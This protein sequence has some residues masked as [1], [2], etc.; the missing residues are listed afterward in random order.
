MTS[1]GPEQQEQAIIEPTVLDNGI[2]DDD[3]ELAA[4]A[5][6]ACEIR[7]MEA[8]ITQ[9]MPA[10]ALCEQNL[11]KRESFE[12]S[13]SSAHSLTDRG[14]QTRAHPKQKE[15]HEQ[16]KNDRSSPT[17]QIKTN[18][19]SSPKDERGKQRLVTMTVMP[20]EMGASM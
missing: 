8:I 20:M 7:P 17:D 12:N 4:D 18:E 3:E 5:G 10:I 2:Y 1:R 13:N 19:V 16:Q 14:L 9:R 6:H 11:N 15:K